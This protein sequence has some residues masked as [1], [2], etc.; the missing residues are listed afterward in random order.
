MKPRPRRF[1]ELA[2]LVTRGRVALAVAFVLLVL[3]FLVLALETQARPRQRFR[4]QDPDLPVRKSG[5]DAGRARPTS[6]RGARTVVTGRIAQVS[7]LPDPKTSPYTGCVL[8]VKLEVEEILAGR[9]VPEDVIVAFWGF[10]HRVLRRAADYAPGDTV[11][12]S[13]VPFDEAHDDIRTAQRAD[14][15]EDLDL[16][17]F[18]AGRTRSP[19]RSLRAAHAPAG[20]SGH[21]GPAKVPT[22]GTG[23]RGVAAQRLRDASIERDKEAIDAALER[24]GGSWASWF[25]ELAPMRK[26]I[27]EKLRDS[28]GSLS[29]GGFYFQNMEYLD[30][31]WDPGDGWMTTPLEMLAHLNW[32]LRKRGIDLIVLPFPPKEDVC[33]DVFADNAP[34]DGIFQPHKLRLFRA[35]LEAD[36]E[37]IDVTPHLMDGRQDHPLLYYPCADHHPADGAILI[38]AKVIAGRLSR[39][40]FL[41]ESSAAKGRFVLRRRSLIIPSHYTDFPP[42]ASFS[43]HQVLERRGGAAT[44]VP[45]NGS[46]IL[47]FGVSFVLVPKQYGCPSANLPAHI[48]K[49]T[50]VIPSRMMVASGG[51]RMMRHLARQGAG[52]LAARRVC[53]FAFNARYAYVRKGQEADWRWDWA[54]V[55]LPVQR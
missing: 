10:K 25:D 28:G 9:G 37:V 14:D 3:F 34:A 8:F 17:V 33:A 44:Q 22:L 18:W 13:L 55:D 16:P 20:A 19:G 53:V 15:I 27:R 49:E 12:L 36:V 52:L 32:E 47:A 38:A 42:G 4:P 41:A 51:P 2:A 30:M 7:R 43:A 24:H 39:Y 35:L 50:G 26:D 6:R 54:V 40:D 23:P 29:Q 46:P 45:S 1:R 48:A 11:L 21:G 5:V 31:R